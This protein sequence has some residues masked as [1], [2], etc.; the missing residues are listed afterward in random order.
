MVW[1]IIGIVAL[2]A[3]VWAFW[4]RRRGVVDAQ[5]VHQQ[6][7]DQGFVEQHRRPDTPGG[8]GMNF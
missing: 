5:V 2:G 4:P 1:I 6:H 7:V 3:G 8:M